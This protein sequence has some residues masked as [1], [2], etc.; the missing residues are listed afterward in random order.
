MTVDKREE[1][2]KLRFQSELP[3]SEDNFIGK[4]HQN[5]AHGLFEV[6]EEHP[7]VHILGV[8]GG[9]GAGKS[10]SIKILESLLDSDKYQFIY[11][12]VDQHHYASTKSA[13]IKEYYNGL[14]EIICDNKKS[15]AE[16]FKNEALGN[17]LEYT[18]TTKSTISI[19]VV[20][21]AVSI[22]FFARH[23]KES[24]EIML[25]SLFYFLDGGWAF[26]FEKTAVV[27]LSLSPF[28]V[29]FFMEIR[30]YFLE[31]NG[32]NTG[33]VSV[34]DLLKR[35]GKDTIN[36]TLD[37]TREVG[38][39][40]LKEAFFNLSSLIPDNTTVIL[41]IDNIDR[42]EPSKVREVWSDLDIFT[43]VCN[44]KIRIILPYSEI[45]VANSINPDCWAEGREYIS[46]RLPVV[47]RAPPIV[48]AGWR[49][50]YRK[51]WSE[52]LGEIIGVEE[53]AELIEIW[54]DGSMQITPRLLKKH[55]NDIY[56][57]IKSNN[58]SVEDATICSAYLL[59]VKYNNVSLEEL[60]SL[61]SKVSSTEVDK[62][63]PPSNTQ[64][65]TRKIRAVQKVL[66]TE[67]DPEVWTV[68]IACIHYQ[69]SEEIARS[70]L[71][72]DPI[73]QA[74]TRCDSKQILRLSSV[75]G[76]NV[77]FEKELRDSSSIEFI[78]LS[79]NVIESKIEGKDLW[80]EKWLPKIN[81][82]AKQELT[83]SECDVEYIESIKVLADE[84]G[85][86]VEIV[87]IEKGISDIQHS[88][89]NDVDTADDLLDDLHSY[90]R[91]KEET[92]SLIR[93]AP[94][95]LFVDKIWS[96]RSDFPIWDL[97]SVNLGK[98]NRIGI[99]SRAVSAYKK[100]NG[101]YDIFAWL[102]SYH[103]LR[104]ID[105]DDEGS[106]TA[107]LE[108]N[109]SSL[110]EFDCFLIPYCRNWASLDNV[111]LLLSGLK[112]GG[113]EKHLD[114][115]IALVLVG[116]ACNN[117]YGDNF[118][119]KVGQNVVNVSV[120]EFL[121]Q[122]MENSDGYK[123][124]LSR[125]LTFA[126]NFHRV[127][128]SLRNEDVSRILSASIKEVIGNGKV[129]AFSIDELLVGDSYKNLS[130]L[131]D[132][133]EKSGLLE[134]L[135]NWMRHLSLS[136]DDFSE[137]FVSD[138]ILYDKKPWKD[139]LVSALED[140]LKD[141]EFCLSQLERPS[142]NFKGLLVWIKNKDRKIKSSKEIRLVLERVFL[143]MSDADLSSYNNRDIINSII[144]VLPENSKDRVV[145]KFQSRLM[146]QTASLHERYAIIR[147]F[148]DYLELEDA[149][150]SSAINI[151]I[152]LVERAEENEVAQWLNK[153]E[154]SF[155]S[156]SDEQKRQVFNA[157]SNHDNDLDF[158]TILNH[159]ELKGVGGGA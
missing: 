95:E 5:A 159:E 146:E 9:L 139:K 137:E 1:T 56:C 87:L 81:Q 117:K 92:P 35:N 129:H 72:R 84:Y 64:S 115:W 26:S 33:R 76:F 70:E 53:S 36:E 58:S 59:S 78:K 68:K 94:P 108:V 47:F 43:S 123:E 101:F 148:G 154:W 118:S 28:F 63:Q 121:S 114:E 113:I 145:R 46:K 124:C 158:P 42:V 41:V 73:R 75:F 4:G 133:S 100:D 91:V 155:S 144:D 147:N 57:V 45:H 38:S 20:M 141:N 109:Y 140:S 22:F 79:R 37:I 24:L 82:K 97:E 39:F 67:S 98:E 55:V 49:E 7:Y 14:C 2:E 150:S 16:K 86:D 21:F 85:Q 93:Q 48:S 12:D 25:S 40:E 61:Q 126:P 52:T 65:V 143:S 103:K 19:Y 153:Q 29:Y 50:Q 90:S 96:R 104:E 69:T 15:A 80:V 18:K 83:P 131:Y 27:L 88:I 30:N 125:F 122:L 107:N 60:L 130:R 54:Q 110:K 112:S 13:F 77:F 134:F 111:N 152:M 136:L 127:I 3:S 151:Y 102:M 32:N 156:W 119:C 74:V 132:D 51:Y 99:L 23:F 6:I 138:V 157:V 31:K 120:K 116:V 66:S 105:F 62:N 8:E 17:T 71:L 44:E 106:P 135:E 149:K 89:I 142:Y 128:E 10:T 11:F 34:G